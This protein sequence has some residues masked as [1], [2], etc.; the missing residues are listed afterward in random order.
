MARR[1]RGKSRAQSQAEQADLYDLYEAAVQDPEGDVA[2]LQRIY[3]T[4]YDRDPHV[5]REDFCGTAALCCA[6]VKADADN[7]AYG[8][9]IDAHPLTWARKKSFPK[10]GPVLASRV[11]LLQGDVREVKHEAVDVTV[12]FNFSY[13]I[14]QDRA[15]LLRYFRR[16]YESLGPRGLF[17]VDL[18]GG[19]DSQRTMT[20]TRPLHFDYVW[21]QDPSTRSTTAR[22]TTSTSSSRTAAGSIA[23]STMTGGSGVPEVRCA[24]DAASRAPRPT[25]AHRPQGNEGTGVLPRQARRTIR[26]GWRTSLRCPEVPALP[27]RLHNSLTGRVEDLLPQVPGEVRMYHCGPTVYK[28]QHIGNFRAFMLADLLRRTFEMQ[29]RRVTQIM[30]ITD[31]GRRTTPPMLRVR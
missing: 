19:A 10:L 2:L 1:R 3:R 21:D 26:R 23:R 9:D 29:G 25:G 18:Y 27:M 12:G 7:R 22:S 31:V 14:F 16:A 15:N 5:L 8:I 30:N 20:E 11:T 4:Y 17:V 28:R 6:W 24:H 13:F